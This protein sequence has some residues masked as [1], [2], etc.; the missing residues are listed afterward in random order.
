MI[1]AFRGPAD[2]SVKALEILDDP[3]R[4]FV[5]S[6]FV[7]LELLPKPLF[8]QHRLEVVFYRAFFENVSVWAEVSHELVVAAE[9]LATKYGLSA[10]DGL[11]GA[12]ALAVGATEL[13]TT[14]KQSKPIHRLPGLSVV[15]LL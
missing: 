9:H 15:S 4:R 13:V 14:E 11:H 10:L 5:S 12:A 7:R 8:T 3:D 2:L 1:A 6:P